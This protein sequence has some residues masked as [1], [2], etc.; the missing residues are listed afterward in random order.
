MAQQAREDGQ[1]PQVHAVTK[2]ISGDEGLLASAATHTHTAKELLQKLGDTAH[3]EAKQSDDDRAFQACTCARELLQELS[4]FEAHSQALRDLETQF[5]P[6]S[7]T[8]TLFDFQVHPARSGH[9][10]SLLPL[11]LAPFRAGRA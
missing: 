10:C 3:E 11:M 5:T 1:D 7:S 6:S 8:G 2:A 9:S 4:R